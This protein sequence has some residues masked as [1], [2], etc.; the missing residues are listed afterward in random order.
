LHQDYRQTNLPW[1]SAERNVAFPLLLTG[2]STGEAYGRARNMLSIL[3]PEVGASHPCFELSGGQQQ[4]LALAR[5]LIAK[6]DAVLGD[7]P[8]SAVDAVRRVRSIR[9]LT[10]E[11]RR[12]RVPVLWVSHDVEEAL[13]LADRIVLLSR[14]RRRVEMITDN[15]IEAASR[16]IEALGEREVQL[17]K[18]AIMAHLVKDFEVGGRVG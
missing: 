17:L 9:A 16:S 10:E 6:P 11:W 7:E 1:A 2:I 13:L 5:A 14:Q 12:H 4:L 3:L 18:A 15:P 8:M